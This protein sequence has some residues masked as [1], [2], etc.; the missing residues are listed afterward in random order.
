MGRVRFFFF[1]FFFFLSAKQGKIHSDNQKI[2]I[3]YFSG[4]ASEPLL[5][6]R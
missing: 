4:K 6:Q 2:C 3:V 5:V 1:F